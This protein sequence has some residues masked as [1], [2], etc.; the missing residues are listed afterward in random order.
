EKLVQVAQDNPR[1]EGMGTTWT[2]AYVVGWDA[3]IAHIGDSRA[4]IYRE[5]KLNRLTRDHTLGQALADRGAGK[6]ESD[7]FR[8]IVT[9]TLGGRNGEGVPDVEHVILQSGDR[10]L[11]CTDGLS[12]CV[13]HAEISEVLRQVAEPQAACDALIERALNHGGK[14]NVT[15]V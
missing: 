11:L 15:V 12:D 10:L 7:Q 14:D 2:S 4:Y 6:E 3:I 13:P 9:N 5:D 8:H 1:L